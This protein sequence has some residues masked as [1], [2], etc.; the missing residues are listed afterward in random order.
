MAKATRTKFPIARLIGFERT[1]IADRTRSRP[2]SRPDR[3]T[4]SHGH[5]P[6]RIL[7]DIATAA[8]A[9][10][11]HSTLAPGESFTT[12]ELKL[13]SSALCGSPPPRRGKVVRRG[14]TVGYIECEIT[15][16][17]AT[18]SPSPPQPAWSPR[19]AP[20]TLNSAIVDQKSTAPR[21][22]AF[23]LPRFFHSVM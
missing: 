14:S 3:N 8:M 4:K 15:D 19:A 10:P 13:I 12:I 2:L 7:C 1:K 23:F 18:S 5:S 6:W 9:W 21:R 22:Q 17:A 11:S 16:E 20:K